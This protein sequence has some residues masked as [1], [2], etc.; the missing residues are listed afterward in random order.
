MPLS[1]DDF[2]RDINAVT[3]PAPLLGEVTT[4]W[5][6]LPEAEWRDFDRRLE[7]VLNFVA[8][9]ETGDHAPMLAMAIALRLMALDAIVHN[10][11]HRAWLFPGAQEGITFLHGDI[12]KAAAQAELL[13]GADGNPTFAQEAFRMRLMTLA[14]AR[15]QA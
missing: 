11:E 9:R 1:D 14:A 3:V 10:P 2:L 6:A 5:A 13:T 4:L 15:G 8:E 12:V 7:H